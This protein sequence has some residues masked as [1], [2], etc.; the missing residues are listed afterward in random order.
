MTWEKT[1]RVCRFSRES[2]EPRKTVLLSA[3]S[4]TTHDSRATV[5]K[6]VIG[7]TG[8]MES[9]SQDRAGRTRKATTQ[10]QYG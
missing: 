2:T 1:L 4:E 6:H 8:G 3:S 7:G 5:V 9:L 10:K